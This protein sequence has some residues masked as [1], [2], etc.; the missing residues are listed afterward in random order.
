ML[1]KILKKN[2]YKIGSTSSI[3]MLFLWNKYQNNEK[4]CIICFF[5]DV[6]RT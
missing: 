2:S 5:M 6:A 1:L 4:K 3:L